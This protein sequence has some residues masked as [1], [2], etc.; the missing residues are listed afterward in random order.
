MTIKN[1]RILFIVLL[2]FLSILAAAYR[3]G[4]Y[5]VSFLGH[6][7][8]V[9]AHRVNSTEKL[10]FALQYFNGIELDLVYISKKNYF[11]VNHPPT[12]S[13]GLTFE[14][15]L[16]NIKLDAQPF[17]WL[18]IKNLRTN[19][20]EKIKNHLCELFN[21]VQFP[22]DKVLIESSSIEA[23]LPFTKIGVKTTLNFSVVLNNLKNPNFL[24]ENRN[25]DSILNSHTEI[26]VSASYRHY[27]VVNSRFPSRDK[28][29][30]I[31]S[32][33]KIKEHRLVRSILNNDKVKVVLA[34]YGPITGNR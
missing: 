13:I 7:D 24:R 32:H 1:R 9:W 23:L 12:E 8:K 15:Y 31:L 11:D 5:K 20:S 17:L 19:N 30:W 16:S 18:D 29:I 10:S 3:Y 27:G 28:Y 25:L 34:P 6:Y 14:N 22:L 33:S 4:P 26:G 21:K 2:F